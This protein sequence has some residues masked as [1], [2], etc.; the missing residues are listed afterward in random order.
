MKR[1]ACLFSSVLALLIISTVGFAQGTTSRVTGV[2]FDP[3]G[4]AVAGGTVT[5]TNEGSRQQQTGE[6]FF[7]ESRQF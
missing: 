4:A 2:V 5:F 6:T 3:Q 1:I 7:G